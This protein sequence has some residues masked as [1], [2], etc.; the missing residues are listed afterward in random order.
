MPAYNRNQLIA[1]IWPS[2]RRC[3]K[4]FTGKNLAY[5]TIKTRI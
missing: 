2:I 3:H 1:Q 5:G 4:D